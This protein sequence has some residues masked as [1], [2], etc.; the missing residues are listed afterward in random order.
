M[1]TARPASRDASRQPPHGYRPCLSH[2]KPEFYSIFL[3]ASL[4]LSRPFHLERETTGKC[5]LRSFQ[6]RDLPQAASLS[7]QVTAS[8]S[9][10]P[11]QFYSIFLL[12]PTPTDRSHSHHLTSPEPLSALCEA[13]TSRNHRRVFSCVVVPV[14]L[15]F[16]SLC[17]PY[18]FEL[19]PG[20][21]SETT[22]IYFFLTDL[23]L[24][25]GA[26]GSLGTNFSSF[27]TAKTGTPT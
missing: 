9:P 19:I 7:F 11:Q 3:L 2:S 22:T 10:F 14:S 12:H 4:S 1:F 6:S 13:E 25:I 8:S 27:S 15:S 18:I 23:P 20:S 5:L 16:F 17:M 21:S 26:S 24:L